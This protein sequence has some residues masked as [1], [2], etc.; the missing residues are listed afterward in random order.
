MFMSEHPTFRVGMSP[1]HLAL[2]AICTALF[3]GSL[4]A[5]IA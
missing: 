3:L 4:A 5:W 1:L 2:E